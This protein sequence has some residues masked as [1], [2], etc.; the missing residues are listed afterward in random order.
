MGLRH[1]GERVR[2]K[3]SGYSSKL[4][5]MSS[6]HR[7]NIASMAE[8][9]EREDYTTMH[10]QSKQQVA[11]GLTKIIPPAGWPEML[12]PL[13]L[14]VHPP[15]LAQVSLASITSA[16]EYARSIPHVVDSK[17]SSNCCHTCQS[18]HPRHIVSVPGRSLSVDER[19]P[20]TET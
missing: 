9:L 17:T 14:G 3:S 11:N 8:I 7:V 10:V 6:V 4:R 18:V 15:V 2:R 20:S 16:E 19:L 5:H 12:Q 1:V 13:S